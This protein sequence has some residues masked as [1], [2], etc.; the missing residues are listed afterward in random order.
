MNLVVDLKRFNII[1]FFNI[2]KEFI[3][4]QNTS[5]LI[6]DENDNI[7]KEIKAVI[8]AEKIEVVWAE[9]EVKD[10]HK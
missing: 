7:L 3:F 6:R 9:Y 10:L 8:W 1:Q 4:A 2:M 5:L